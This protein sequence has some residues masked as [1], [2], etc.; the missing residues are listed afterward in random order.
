MTTTMYDGDGEVTETVDPLNRMTTTMFDGDGEVTETVAPLGHMT[1]TMYDADGEVT[2]TVDPLGHMT[3]TMYDA[4]GEV[5]ETID[6]LGNNTTT[7]YDADGEVTETIDPLGHMTTTMYDADGEVTEAIDAQGRTTTSLYD[8]DGRLLSQ[9]WEDAHGNV[10]NTETYSYDADGELLTAGNSNGTYTMTYDAL[11]RVISVQNPFGL[12][13]TYTYDAD[14]NRTELQDSLGGVTTCLYDPDNELTSEQFGGTGQTPLRI[15]MTYD[16]DREILTE[17]RYSDLAGTQVVVRS[18]YTY[19]ADGE[20]TSLLDRNGGGT[21][22]ASFTY[23]YDLDNRVATEVNMGMT[24]T[25]TYDAGSELTSEVS[26]L[27]T[28]DYS[29][30]AGGNRTSGNSVIGPGNQLLSDNNWTYTYDADGNLIQKVGV[31]TGPDHGLTWTYAYDNRNQMTSAVEVQ[32]ST[33]LASVS[34]KYDVFGDRIEEDASGSMLPTQVTRFAYDG[35][36]VWADLDGSNNLVMRRLFLAAVDSVAARTSASGTVVWYLADRLGS[37]NVLTDATGAVI[38]RILYDGYGNVISETNASASDRYLWTGREFDRVTGLQYNRARYYDPQIGRWTSLDPEGFAAGDENLY[39]Y[40]HN[41]PTN[42]SDPSGLAN[43]ILVKE[44]LKYLGKK[45]DNEKRTVEKTGI[46][47]AYLDSDQAIHFRFQYKKANEDDKGVLGVEVH[48]LQFV[49]RT[50]TDKEGRQPVCKP[51][52]PN[53]GFTAYYDPRKLVHFFNGAWHVDKIDKNKEKPFYDQR[54][55]AEKN[56]K[57]N[58]VDIH[59]KPDNL[60]PPATRFK[61]T[62]ALFETYL[63]LDDQVR[64][65]IRWSSKEV[66]EGDKWKPGVIGDVKG[67]AV[68]RLP[69]Y[70]L[71]DKLFGGFEEKD[72]KITGEFYYVNPIPADKR[73][74]K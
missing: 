59:D 71:E 63:I 27:A 47:Y 2:E 26:P 14:G 58:W 9:T 49:R 60:A 30:D 38:D 12:T 54:K 66:L 67:E 36:N 72:N 1:T 40:A 41:D 42:S 10:T 17:T 11:K 5:T 68:D 37:V 3:T 57:P 64:Y 39:R 15:D 29:Y 35:Q 22:V 34:F 33:T 61:E 50:V 69:D 70:A 73:K 23:T 51:E 48:F 6:S 13:L 18:F 46:V 62:S 24:T 28:I 53:N 20:I 52:G 16:A 74:K 44:E 43:K 31:A 55:D 25:Y 45:G 32:G 8:A 65:V 19:N 4:D 7:V 21:V 56:R